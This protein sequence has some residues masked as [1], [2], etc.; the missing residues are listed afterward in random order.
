[1]SDSMRERAIRKK[2]DMPI[3]L[4]KRTVHSPI[5]RASLSEL[6]RQYANK[7]VAE[8]Y[9]GCA[10]ITD[11]GTPWVVIVDP[12]KGRA[13]SFK[14]EQGMGVLGWLWNV[15]PSMYFSLTLLSRKNSRPHARWMTPSGSE[16]AQAIL[17]GRL[18]LCISDTAGNNSGWFDMQFME[19]MG[20]DAS[21]CTKALKAQWSHSLSGIPR[22]R[23]GVRLDPQWDDPGHAPDMEDDDQENDEIPMWSEQTS[24]LW[25]TLATRGPWNE[26]LQDRDKKRAAWATDFHWRRGRA[27]AYIQVIRDRQSIDG[28]ASLVDGQKRWI[29]D[30]GSDTTRRISRVLEEYPLVANLL[31]E[32][33]GHDPDAKRAHESAIKVLQDPAS[34]FAFVAELL[35]LYRGTDDHAFGYALQTCFETAIRDDRFTDAGRLRPWLR[36]LGGSQLK[37]ESFPLDQDC[38]ISDLKNFWRNGLDMAELLDAGLWFGPRDMPIPL[39]DLNEALATVAIEGDVEAAAQRV[40]ELLFEAQEARQWSIPWGARV[41]IQLPPFVAVRVHEAKGEFSCHFLD[42]QDRYLHVAIGLDGEKPRIT[43]VPFVKEVENGD[44]VWNNDASLTVQLIAAAIVRDFLVVEERE[45]LFTARTIRK[46]VKGKAK[47]TIVYL[48]R[49]R[50]SRVSTA[51]ADS[52]ESLQRRARYEVSHH[53]RKA[54]LPS[55]GQ[56]LLALKYGITL[57]KG[58]TFVRA[59]SRGG[60]KADDRLRTY[61]SR[62]ASR[63]LFTS[64]DTLPAGSRPAWFE[65]EKGC[66]RLLKG[67]GMTVVHQSAHRD[68]DG[69]VDL[70]ATDEAGQSW[71]VQCKCWATHRPVGPDVVRELIGAIN[72]ADVGSSVTSKGMVITT[73]RFTEGAVELADSLDIVLID[74][75]AFVKEDT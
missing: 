55:P 12:V 44:P 61:R 39:G 36:N 43:D 46:M 73:S 10:G 62:S 2:S 52:A 18:L 23:K 3:A 48:P 75:D 67:R 8:C 57:P 9:P 31:A 51:G 63:M 20:A 5:D 40:Q 27:A 64:L 49:V 7:S 6:V 21:P 1:M 54:A 16:V 26:D 33:C 30:A 50:Y 13:E 65:F 70:Y 66:A 24:D 29:K 17:G 74:G 41:E 11:D 58:F 34:L 38:K 71:V 28:Q 60:E 22:S 25:K 32:V 14:R 19:G 69:G 68:G 4:G 37:I 56:R 15:T 47:S 35:P 45:S 72:G 59:H 42:D 53:L